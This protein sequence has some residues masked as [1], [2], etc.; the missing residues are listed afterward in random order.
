MPTTNLRK[1]LVISTLATMLPFY[2][3]EGFANVGLDSLLRGN[4]QGSEPSSLTTVVEDPSKVDPRYRIAHNPPETRK[5]IQTYVPEESVM[6]H[7]GLESIFKRMQL[8]HKLMYGYASAKLQ[9]KGDKDIQKMLKEIYLEVRGTKLGKGNNK[10]TYYNFFDIFANYHLFSIK[11]RPEINP[12]FDR[13]ILPILKKNSSLRR[14]TL[15]DIR[16]NRDGTW[17]VVRFELMPGFVDEEGK[18]SK[19]YRQ[20]LERI[21]K[22]F[23]AP[24]IADLEP[25]FQ[26]RYWF[27]NPYYSPPN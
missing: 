17:K 22:T 19:F 26:A 2:P 8:E 11:P 23:I 4:P 21:P 24:M 12:E 3:G 9:N 15:A 6:L 7:V 25:P 1:G 10:D 14:I 18:A 16:F 5:E 13:D 20:K 27:L